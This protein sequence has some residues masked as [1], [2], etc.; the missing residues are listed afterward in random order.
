M[1]KFNKLKH[2]ISVPKFYS[3]TKEEPTDSLEGINS[4]VKTHLLFSYMT[5]KKKPIVLF[6]AAASYLRS[7]LIFTAK[8]SLIYCDLDTIIMT[9]S[10]TTLT[11]TF[12]GPRHVLGF[13]QSATGDDS[14]GVLPVL[15]PRDT[16]RIQ[17]HERLWQPYV[18]TRQQGQSG[19]LLQIS[20]E[21]SIVLTSD[22]LEFLVN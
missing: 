17:V 19:C 18:Q 9:L 10:H 12:S 4:S 5:T 8:S 16:Q 22:G 1:K 13:H 2:S 6:L 20:L 11:L 15:G 21:G 14:P 7:M 3:H